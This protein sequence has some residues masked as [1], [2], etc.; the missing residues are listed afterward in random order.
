[1]VL[2]APVENR[3][4]RQQHLVFD[5]PMAILGLNPLLA[6]HGPQTVLRSVGLFGELK[7]A[8]AK[9]DTFYCGRAG[10]CDLPLLKFSGSQEHESRFS[11]PMRPNLILPTF[12]ASQTI[13]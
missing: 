12:L 10:C 13:V 7:E 3:V 5:F 6:G 4:A 9:V 2:R 8:Q 11:L 1:V